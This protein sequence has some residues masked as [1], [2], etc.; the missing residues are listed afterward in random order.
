MDEHPRVLNYRRDGLPPDAVYIGRRNPRYR[1]R[2]SKWA[3]P[4]IP[5]RQT[6][7]QHAEVVARYEQHLHESG[8]IKDVGELRGKDL[9]C[10]CSPLP[11]HGDGCCGWPTPQ[12]ASEPIRSL[13]ARFWGRF[14]ADLR[15]VRARLGKRPTAGCDHRGRCRAGLVQGSSEWKSGAD[16]MSTCRSRWAL[17]SSGSSRAPDDPG[18]AGAI[19]NVIAKLRGKGPWPDTVVDAAIGAVAAR[20][21]GLRRDGARYRRS[22]LCQGGAFNRCEKELLT[23]WSLVRI[24]PGEPRQIGLF[25]THGLRFIPET[26]VTLLVRRDFRSVRACMSPGRSTRDRSP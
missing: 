7:E 16:G 21:G 24:R 23:G 1:L 15:E 22:S 8:L 6:H 2:A 12:R 9:V 19:C 26:W 17:S 18:L 13:P 5:R 25:R 20:L 11:C 10:W 14:R 4:F 3:N